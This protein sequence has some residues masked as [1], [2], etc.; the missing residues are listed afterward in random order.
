[1][2]VVGY[3]TRKFLSFLRWFFTFFGAFT[4]GTQYAQLHPEAFSGPIK[5][6]LYS[7][8]LLSVLS[9]LLLVPNRKR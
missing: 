7:G 1:M 4:V 6:L 8:A 3:V 9:Y 5:D 2:E